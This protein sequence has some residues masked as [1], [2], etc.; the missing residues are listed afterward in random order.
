[1]NFEVTTQGDVTVVEVTGQL[2]VGNRQELKDDVLKLLE[3]GHRKFLIDFKDTA[4]I[5]SSGLGVLVSLSKKIREKGGEMRLSNL[6]E[7]LRTL[8]ELTK[9]DTLFLIADSRDE[10]LTDF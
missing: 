8:F 1:M 10:A 9:L 2:I 3:D 4:Y 6:N 5:D 7:D